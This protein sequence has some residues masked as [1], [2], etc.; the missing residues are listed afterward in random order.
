MQR[1]V[2]DPFVQVIF[3]LLI[4]FRSIFQFLQGLELT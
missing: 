1:M 4:N 3:K 2:G